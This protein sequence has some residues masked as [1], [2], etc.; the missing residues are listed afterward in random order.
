MKALLQHVGDR[1]KRRI[2]EK[3]R[4]RAFEPGIGSS[5]NLFAKALHQARFA[6]AGFADNRDDLT[7]ALAHALPTIH[8]Q[9]QFVLAPDE[10]GH[11]AHCRL[12]P[13][14]RPR[15]PLGRTTR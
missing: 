8:Q 1:I 15:I 4:G 13:A 12:P 2:L 11:P 5:G 6:D 9:T 7:F 14:S 3:W 10:R